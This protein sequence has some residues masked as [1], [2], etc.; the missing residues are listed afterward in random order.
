MS[1]RRW[2]RFAV[3]L[4]AVVLAGLLTAVP[5][6]GISLDDALF[7][8]SGDLGDP[9]PGT[10]EWE[11]ADENNRWCANHGT[12]V[13][14]SNPARLAAMAA[15]MAQGGL[16]GG[17]PFRE[18]T[19]RWDGVRGEFEELTWTDGDGVERVGLL[20]GPL[21]ATATTCHQQ[22]SKQR[23]TLPNRPTPPGLESNNP[24]LHQTQ[25]GSVGAEI[26]A[27]Q[28]R[29]EPGAEP[30]PPLGVQGASS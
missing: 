10:P 5:T 11:A 29:I 12:V 16:R 22:S 19:V 3:P 13:Y 6:K 21:T 28:P 18:P 26:A 2:H 25:G 20:F 30:A 1:K 7:D 9:M 17:D 14:Q 27:T 8:C 24:S 4:V 23:S 15:N